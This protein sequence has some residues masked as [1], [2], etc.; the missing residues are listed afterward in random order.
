MFNL[1]NFLIEFSEAIANAKMYGLP[2]WKKTCEELKD[3]LKAEFARLQDIEKKALEQSRYIQ[4]NGLSEYERLG[5]EGKIDKL[6]AN[7]AN[8]KSQLD[9]ANDLA[10]ARYEDV[11]LLNAGFK[12]Q[13]DALKSLQEMLDSHND[14]NP[15]LGITA[16]VTLKL[17]ELERLKADLAHCE[18]KK[19]TVSELDKSTI[20]WIRSERDAIKKH[21]KS[22]VIQ[23]N[24]GDDLDGYNDLKAHHKEHHEN[25]DCL[26]AEIR[27]L[28]RSL[29]SESAG[30]SE[31][32]KR[33]VELSS[34]VADMEEDLEG[35]DR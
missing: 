34:R 8:L 20:D 23:L 5:L 24:R 19:Q 12:W 13:V 21:L 27:G 11:K 26:E 30:Y 14:N 6:Q 28:K 2:V 22:L 29:E 4:T 1:D 7:N 15:W 3:T 17:R 31:C 33:V 35:D 16:A 9:L 25:E 32:K 10:N 18:E